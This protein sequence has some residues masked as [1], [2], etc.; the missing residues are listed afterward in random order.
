MCCKGEGD[1]RAQR[2]DVGGARRALV[3]QALVAFDAAVGGIGGVAF[4]VEDFYA[5]DAAVA[6]VDQGIVV[7]HAVGERNAVGR[8]SAGAIDQAG[9]ELLVL[10]LRRRGNRQSG[11]C[12]RSPQKRRLVKSHRV[13]P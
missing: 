7:G 9:N 12:D 6:L 2:V 1:A 11:R 3:L 4:L 5:V 10:G 8:V 13:P